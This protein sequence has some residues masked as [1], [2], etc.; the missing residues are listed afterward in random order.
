MKVQT[1]SL[2]TVVDA[3]SETLFKVVSDFGLYKNW[4]TVIPDAKGELK[5]GTELQLTMVMNGKN[6]TFSP[7]VISIVPNKS[8][9]LSKTIISKVIFELTHEFEFKKITD[10]RTEFIQTWKG[11]GVLALILWKKIKNGFSIFEVFNNNLVKY[12]SKQEE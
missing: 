11:N 1:Y 2:A 6:K 10:H 7:K 8:F 5:E 3:D 4:N 9:L 12:I